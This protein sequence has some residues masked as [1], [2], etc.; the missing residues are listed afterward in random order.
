M[1]ES[2]VKCCD[3]HYEADP[4]DFKVTEEEL[5][6]IFTDRDPNEFSLV[7]KNEQFKLTRASSKANLNRYSYEC[8]SE[9]EP[10][11]LLLQR[12][13]EQGIATVNYK[14]A[15]F[16]HEFAVLF[17]IPRLEDLTDTY[18]KRGFRESNCLSILWN[19]WKWITAFLKQISI[20]GK[21]FIVL[22]D[23]IGVSV[24][25]AFFFNTII[26]FTTTGLYTLE[27]SPAIFV[28]ILLPIVLYSLF[29]VNIM[30]IAVS[31]WFKFTCFTKRSPFASVQILGA[32]IIM[33]T[34][35]N[36]MLKRDYYRMGKTY[37]I[38]IGFLFLV[39]FIIFLIALGVEPAVKG[40]EVFIYIFAIIIPPIKYFA[41]IL[42][43]SIH[44]FLSCFKSCREKFLKEMD[45]TDPFLNAIYT[46]QHYY[47]A[48]IELLKNRKIRARE[49]D[50]MS[51]CSSESSSSY[52]DVEQPFTLPLREINSESNKCCKTPVRVIL[53]AI[54][55]R[56]SATIFVLLASTFYIIFSK[57]ST[58][59]EAA[60]Q[61]LYT[62][63]I[64]ILIVVPLSNWLVMP[65][66]W[67]LRQKGPTMTTS[68]LNDEKRNLKKSND[69]RKYIK[70]L[71]VW[72]K[73]FK[74]MR[75]SSMAISCLIV[76]LII[77]FFFVS[78]VFAR[79]VEQY[80]EEV[81]AEKHAAVIT[82]KSATTTAFTNESQ[83]FRQAKHP[84]CYL[85]V[86]DMDAQQLIALAASAYYFRNI[87]R[88][89][90][91]RL[92]KEYFGD[93]WINDVVEIPG[94][95]PHPYYQ[96]SMTH[97]EIKSK[98]TVVFSIR[99]T[100]S[101]PDMLADLELW[102]G[103]VLIDF[104]I[105]VT[106]LV[107]VFAPSSKSVIGTFMDLPRYIFRKFSLVD[108][109]VEIFEDYIK[110]VNISSTKD[111]IIVGHSLGG[112]LTRIL[113]LRTGIQGVAVSG[114]G[115]SCIKHYYSKNIKNI[116]PTWISINPSMDL[117]AMVDNN[118]DLTE[119]KVPCKGGLFKCHSFFRTLCQSGIL[120]GDSDLHENFCKTEIPSEQYNKMKKL[121]S[122]IDFGQYIE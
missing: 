64:Y 8:P 56:N 87:S 1:G 77:I 111:A 17:D 69:Y 102:T 105:K 39:C 107:E 63:F 13:F 93:D 112:G 62:F 23:L 2:S 4:K 109:Y 28:F 98:N 43:Y 70:D 89:K 25:L 33:L 66:F 120:C 44:C 21:L 60:Y 16:F 36:G 55:S 10:H 67:I 47:Q 91:V 84:L 113:S 78:L 68:M 31:E 40:I 27:R 26:L 38:I 101:L 46:R 72:S 61:F 103:T 108:N 58:R 116:E 81:E 94:P 97:Y 15:E 122:P 106:P 7:I 12:F 29:F 51:S 14:N 49:Q 80:S 32:K 24:I 34:K 121:G 104:V 90:K 115:I 30:T 73:S 65:F 3:L 50:E 119:F 96:C 59:K 53:E 117:V 76:V 82:T 92:F 41:I 20:F 71:A 18:I 83:G 5:D 19:I 37:D 48:V 100:N 79:N 110:S 45:F 88:T 85:T 54:F 99:G 57:S 74:V 42:L 11:A 35:W 86:K 118:R 75:W 52:G 6:V 95:F 114:P 22:Y 9:A